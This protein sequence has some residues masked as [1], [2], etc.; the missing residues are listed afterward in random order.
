MRRSR[1]RI[2]R[3]GAALAALASTLAAC[4][5]AGASARAADPACERWFESLVAVVVC[6]GEIAPTFRIGDVRRPGAHQLRHFPSLKVARLIG[7]ALRPGDWIVL[8][9][10][11]SDDARVAALAVTPQGRPLFAEFDGLG[12]RNG[13]HAVLFVRGTPESPT[14][15]L[16]R[17]DGK[18]VSP[19]AVRRAPGRRYVTDLEVHRFPGLA[20]AIF[21]AAGTTSEVMLLTGANAEGLFEEGEPEGSIPL[22]RTL[23]TKPGQRVAVAVPLVKDA[24]YVYVLPLARSGRVFPALERIPGTK[25]GPKGKPHGGH[26]S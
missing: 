24:A 19:T 26:P 15:L 8:S 6:D 3:A 25:I 21:T 11:A 14:F 10:K 5:G 13:G 23:R 9:G 12:L 22:L 2:V 17:G 1:G 7:P 4:G 16:R 18:L 20:H